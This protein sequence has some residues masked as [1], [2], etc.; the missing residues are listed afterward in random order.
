LWCKECGA[1]KEIIYR[2]GYKTPFEI[3]FIPNKYEGPV[4]EEE[5]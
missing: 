3:L 5:E 2:H 4:D 1:V